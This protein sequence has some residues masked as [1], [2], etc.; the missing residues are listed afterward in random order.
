MIRLVVGEG[1]TGPLRLLAD[2]AVVNAG[3]PDE[4]LPKTLL[5]FARALLQLAKGKGPQALELPRAELL[6]LL[7]VD[8]SDAVLR[9]VRRGRPRSAVVR[10][11]T[12]DLR[13]LGVAVAAALEPVPRTAP[14]RRSLAKLPSPPALR[15]LPGFQ[16]E[17]AAGPLTLAVSIDEVPSPRGSAWH[18]L[19]APGAI[20]VRQAGHVVARSA[21]PPFLVLEDLARW[22]RNALK[23]AKKNDALPFSQG[24]ELALD[25]DDVRLGRHRFP[26]LRLPLAAAIGEL[27]QQF[28]KE[29]GRIAPPLARTAPLRTLAHE[30]TPLLSRARQRPLTPARATKPRPARTQRPA[31]PVAHGSVRK[32]SF[33]PLF[34]AR[35]GYPVRALD[36]WGDKVLV[37][38]EEA[39]TLLGLDGTL[40]WTVPARTVAANGLV[41]AIRGERLVRLDLETGGWRWFRDSEG[42]EPRNLV[43]RSPQTMIVEETDALT[44]RLTETGLARWHFRP[45]MGER[46]FASYQPDR[47]YAATAG[48]QL[49]SL[50]PDTG[51]PHFRALSPRPFRQAPLRVGGGLFVVVQGEASDE[52]LQADAA[53]AAVR[54]GGELHA[55]EAGPLQALG[56]TVATVARTGEGWV[57]VLLDKRTG[58]GRHLPTGFTGRRPPEL[59][60]TEA[61]FLVAA[62]DGRALLFAP[63]GT[64]RLAHTEAK[65]PT[66]RAIPPVLQRRLALVASEEPAL[67]DLS[68]GRLVAR[69]PALE[70]LTALAADAELRVVVADEAGNVRGHQ[71]RGHLAVVPDRPKP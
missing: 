19:L 55:R 38:G 50:D 61:G 52:L 40:R 34:E 69:L 5:A 8:G 45:P 20:E 31:E 42:L 30:A 54:W 14:L 47:I 46:V 41:L 6:W 66:A 60:G 2:G 43:Y 4:P 21:E 70:G 68:E 22:A 11:A 16:L 65:P 44:G 37:R 49:A 28:A 1:R 57:L 51:E 25:G 13:A 3:L 7:E 64:P 53:T 26:E 59:V 12:L 67:F 18:G 62:D 10:K 32:L 23:P 15:A 48:G 9:W 71:L 63:D 17:A 35:V 39:T 36:L 56:E 29:L 33:K 27:L 58:D 24:G